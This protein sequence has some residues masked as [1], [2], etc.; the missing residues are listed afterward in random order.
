MT[1]PVLACRGLEAGYDGTAVLR[2]VDLELGRDELVALLGPSGSGKSTLLSCVAGFVH[3]TAGE[4]EVE[5]RL[6]ASARTSLPPEGRGIAV[7]F[8][9]YALW[10]HLTAAETVAYPL[11]RAGLGRAVARERALE[12]LESLGLAALSER[13]PAALSG[14]EQQ[15]VGVARALARE[16]VL[17]LMDEPTSHLDAELRATVQT[18]LSAR[19]RSAG[20]AALYA[21][22]DAGEALAVADRVVILRLG[23]VVQ[24]GTPTEIYEQ[25]ADVW[26]A[27]LTGPASVVPAGAVAT[28]RDV[29]W[30][31]P[32]GK[33]H[34]PPPAARDPSA[35]VEQSLLVRP[36]WACLGGP[37]P[38]RVAHVAFRGPHTDYRLE[39]PAGEVIVRE[40]GTPRAGVGDPTGWTLER[41][42]SVPS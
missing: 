39:T 28:G 9:H 2:G 21:T 38:G 16:P 33:A 11:R 7:V 20:A 6:V 32:G 42:W 36:D 12:L 23:A 27:R 31:A 3:P 41:A 13:R 4:I 26:T 25:P 14:G 35:P 19:R 24:V 18:E 34:G 10:P 1:V 8:Q 29:E 37:L 15:R 17:L 40:P 22:H 30:V 5:G